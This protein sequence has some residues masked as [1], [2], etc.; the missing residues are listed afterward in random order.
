MPAAHSCMPTRPDVRWHLDG[1]PDEVASAKTLSGA[2]VWYPAAELACITKTRPV[3]GMFAVQGQ[4]CS[5]TCSTVN[6]DSSS[7]LQL[8][9]DYLYCTR[10]PHPQ[11]KGVKISDAIADMFNVSSFLASLH[12]WRDIQVK[13]CHITV[14]Q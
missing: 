3:H 5:C 13:P 11:I 1:V 10:E 9:A 6:I 7:F 2:S 8:V 14:L 4:A 12:Y